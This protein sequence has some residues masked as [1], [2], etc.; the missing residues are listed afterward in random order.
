V[1][2]KKV[3][4]INSE[5]DS[6]WEDIFNDIEMTFL[7][8]E[9]V[10]RIVIKFENNVKWDIDVDDSRKK[11]PLEQI[12]DALD[13]LFDEYEDQIETIDFR[14]D[15]ERIKTDLSRRVYRFL[16]LNR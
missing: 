12:E 6:D 3:N 13:E 11:Q 15:L 16:K 14:L 8:I 7:P 10:S 2:K 4:F 1:S 9:Y 5:K